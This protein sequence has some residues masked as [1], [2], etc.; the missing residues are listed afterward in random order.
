MICYI[1]IVG[2]FTIPFQPGRGEMCSILGRSWSAHV[3]SCLPSKKNVVREKVRA[4][5][6]REQSSEIQKCLT[7]S[8]SSKGPA[9]CPGYVD[10]SMTQ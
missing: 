3:W 2:Y 5:K 6:E 9:V 8:S 10:Q 7:E 4:E 1:H